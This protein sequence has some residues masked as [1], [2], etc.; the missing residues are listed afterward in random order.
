MTSIDFLHDN[1]AVGASNSTIEVG[2][3]AVLQRGLRQ[4]LHEAFPGK[5]AGYDRDSII[6][7]ILGTI[8]RCRSDVSSLERWIYLRV[9]HHDPVTY[10]HSI[11]RDIEPVITELSSQFQINAWW[12][13]RKQDTS[14]SAIRLRVAASPSCT[15]SVEKALT[16]TLI[17]RGY[18]VSSLYYEPEV[19]LFGGPGGI[20]IAHELFHRDSLFLARWAQCEEAPRYPIIPV[21][22]SLA[23]MV[24]MTSAA[25]LDTFERWDVFAQISEM[26]P[27]PSGSDASRRREYEELARKVTSAGPD[28]VFALYKGRQGDILR[29]YRAHLVALAG[30]LSRAYFSGGIDCG[31]R[32]FLVPVLIFHLNRAGISWTAQC[33]LAYEVAGEFR[34]ILHKDVNRQAGGLH[35]AT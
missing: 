30:A 3:L 5:L 23:I 17:E 18:D 11:Q 22:L 4:L 24:Y 2:E 1:P 6:E 10:R 16:A 28:A 9:S 35:D 26:R 34:R 8:E 25:G 12:W 20:K 32:E 13:L 7:I 27:L 19:R 21:G 31:L 29:E 33:S 14:G 15:V